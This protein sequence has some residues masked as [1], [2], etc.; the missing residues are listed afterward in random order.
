MTK[1]FLKKK[2]QNFLINSK[3]NKINLK[4]YKINKL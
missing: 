2:N 4:M 3:I 1:I